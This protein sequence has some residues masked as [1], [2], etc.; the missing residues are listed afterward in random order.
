MI[1]NFRIREWFNR[2]D[3]VQHYD[4]SK[5]NKEK[6]RNSQ[7]LEEIGFR[8]DRQRKI[9]KLLSTKAFREARLIHFILILHKMD[10][11]QAPKAR[12]GENC[13]VASRH[14]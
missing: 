8:C 7:H 3:H 4:S 9:D 1:I 2:Q 12:L 5:E 13:G 11:A 10:I 6:G 14:Q